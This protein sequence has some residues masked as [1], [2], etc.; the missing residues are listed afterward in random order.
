MFDR[1]SHRVFPEMSDQGSVQGDTVGA[2]S[3]PE[4][5]CD[6]NEDCSCCCSCCGKSTECCSC[7]IN[8]NVSLK[9]QLLVSFVFVAFIAGG[10][11]LA[12]C[13]GML[14]ALGASA[15]TTADNVIIKNTKSN[16]QN[17]GQEI[18]STINQQL[19]EVQQ[20]VCQVNSLYSTVLLE[21]SYES[22]AGDST[23]LTPMNSYKEYNFVEGCAY[24]NCPKDF[25]PIADRSRLPY[26]PGFVN[27]SLL[28]SSVYLYSSMDGIALRNDS[29][30][31]DAFTNFPQLNTVLNGLAYQDLDFNVMYLRGPNTTVMFYLS[32]EVTV[33]ENTGQF[34]SVHRTFPGILKN[35]TSY[36]PVTRPWFANAPIDGVNMYGPYKETFTKQLVITLSSK[37]STYVPNTLSTPVTIVGAA[38]MLLEDLAKV[39]SNIEYPYMGFGALIT[40]YSN[41]VIVWDGD[42]DVYNENTGTF[43]TVS[44][45]D[46]ILGNYDL[47][48]DRVIDYTDSSGTEWFVTVTTFFP[49]GASESD[50][51]VILVF[52]NKH[53][54]QAP[55]R[56]LNSKI[57][58]TTNQVMPRTVIIVCATV[59]AVIVAVYLLVLYITRPLE[60]MRKISEDM[61]HISAEEEEERD[62]APL[63]RAAFNNL[64]RMDEIGLLAADYYQIISMLQ[65]KSL[66][67]KAKPKN[68][69]NPFFYA[70]HSG[71]E[72]PAEGLS[73]DKLF[74]LWSNKDEKVKEVVEQQ[75][76]SQAAPIQQDDGGLDVLAALKKHPMHKA[77]RDK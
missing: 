62:Y 47:S 5:D 10:V 8:E 69:E 59:G 53:D 7:L 51:L 17:L 23:L 57:T 24:P 4:D 29:A 25:G 16:A 31:N 34:F 13:L 14:Y 65:S 3:S 37:K 60:V 75:S 19:V 68:P 30:W 63:V 64:G 39:V 11:T 67:K 12:I 21:Y 71:E 18:A 44:D 20:S 55:V 42:T 54:A 33:N 76:Q 36:N 73:F 22:A 50:S 15:S 32:A 38:V 1:S 2:V 49:T 70:A 45:F 41:E 77:C 52:T 35:D 43:K 27:G 26:L 74:S 6:C 61:V 40:R 28:D 72:I 58:T 48:Y 9:N 46:A 56:A 66:A